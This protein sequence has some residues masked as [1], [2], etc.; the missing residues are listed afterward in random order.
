L[1]SLRP[2]V[3]EKRKAFLKL[4]RKV[5]VGRLVFVD[6]SGMNCAMTRSHAWVKRGTEF[7][8]RVPMNWGRKSLTLIGAIRLNGWVVLTTMFDT[9]NADRFVAWVRTKLLAKLRRG[10]VVVMDN[11]KAHHDARVVRICAE[12]GIRVIYQSPYSP[13]FNPIEPSW[14]L[15]KQH[16]RKHAPRDP[17]ALRRVARRARYLVTKQH[18]QRWFHHA[19]YQAPLR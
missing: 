11:A 6:E 10:D 7:E 1:E 3:V 17:I 13:D 14:A 12:R 15:Q 16:V 9:A 8:E 2:D 19:G 5:P 18:C 4:I